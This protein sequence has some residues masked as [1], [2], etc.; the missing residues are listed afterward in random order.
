MAFGVDLSDNVVMYAS[1]PANSRLYQ[2]GPPGGSG[3][4]KTRSDRAT[5][6]YALPDP[7]RW[8]GNSIVDFMTRRLPQA[9]GGRDLNMAYVLSGSDGSNTHLLITR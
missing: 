2:F 5:A 7:D 3:T 8:K 9:S 4:E 6:Y 1:D